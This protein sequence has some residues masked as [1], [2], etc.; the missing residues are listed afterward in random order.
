MP[1]FCC[2]RILPT[3]YTHTT[4]NLLLVLVPIN[5]K[6][7]KVNLST[8]S[9]STSYIINQ[10]K[11]HLFGYTCLQSSFKLFVVIVIFIVM[12]QKNMGLQTIL[13]IVS[14]SP[15]LLPPQSCNSSN[16][17]NGC[18]DN[19]GGASKTIS[20]SNRTAETQPEQQRRGR[21]RKKPSRNKHPIMVGSH[22]ELTGTCAK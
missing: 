9:Q 2:G 1:L 6:S 17:R 8:K 19:G 20:S 18:N 22:R 11:K 3:P 21:R 16:D 13:E 7:T 15:P 14:P 4:T 5:P 12:N 10:S